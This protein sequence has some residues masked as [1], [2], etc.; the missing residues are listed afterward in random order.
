[1]QSP[2]PIPEVRPLTDAERELARWMLVH[3][4][5][6]AAAYLD[7]LAHAHV[8]ARCPCGCAS[9]DVAVAGQPASVP[10][11]LSILG[12]YLVGAGDTLSGAFIFARDGVLAGLEVY[13]L[14]GDA[15]RVLPTPDML[16]PMDTPHPAPADEAPNAA[17]PAP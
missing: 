1:M 15:P 10:G 6:G 13:G 11:S 16:R 7:Q 12:D 9:I 4:H 5:P 17:A 8:V 14:A 3:G 2:S